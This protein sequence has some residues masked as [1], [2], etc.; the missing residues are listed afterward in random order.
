MNL[1]KTNIV[2][3]GLLTFA[4]IL[5]IV[6]QF[7]AEPVSD[8]PQ[9]EVS[10]QYNDLIKVT[11]PLPGSTITSP[12][13][14]TGEARGMWFFEASFPIIVVNWD[15]LIIGEGFA[16]ADGEWMTEEYVPFTATVNFTADTSVSPN[17]ALIL[18]KSNASGLPEHDD[19]FEFPVVFG[20]STLTV[21]GGSHT[22]A[23]T[24]WTWVTTEGVGTTPTPDTFI[25][26]FDPNGQLVSSKTDCNSMSGGVEVE[27][28]TLSFGPM[29]TTLMYCEGSL[30]G[31]YGA[32]LAAVSSYEQIGNTLRLNLEQN[33][34]VMVFTRN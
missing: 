16:T 24:S 13:V 19:A 27:N 2:I 4:L 8:I 11:S 15:G 7:L 17:G 26:S 21:A 33:A 22:L 9:E 20:D 34:G 18:Q 30:E 5:A 10:A 25:L 3:L 1:S 32:Q 29:M 28:N 12:L 23:A 6:V 31:E 14:I